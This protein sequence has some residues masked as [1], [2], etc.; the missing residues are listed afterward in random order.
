VTGT[1]EQVGSLGC[2]PGD[3]DI[4]GVVAGEDLAH[5]HTRAAK[6]GSTSMPET[7]GDQPVLS[8]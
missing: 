7:G 5:V 8:A 1:A 3:E 6:V 2:P 4:T